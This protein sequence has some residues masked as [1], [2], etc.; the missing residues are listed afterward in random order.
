MDE[1]KAVLFLSLR[2]V[3]GLNFPDAYE[4][5]VS[6]IAQ[7]CKEHLYLLESQKVNEYDKESREIIATTIK[8]WFEDTA[9]AWN[10]KKLS[11]AVW[12]GDCETI[13]AEINRLL[14]QTHQLS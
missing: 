7:L 12:S 6:V 2:K 4:M 14:R 5:L 13:G 11:A 9:R 10:R 8:G 3:E 1:S